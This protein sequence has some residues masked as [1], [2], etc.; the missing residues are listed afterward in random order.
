MWDYVDTQSDISDAA[1]YNA[2]MYLGEMFTKFTV[3]AMVSAVNEGRERHQYQL[4]YP[5]VR[6][7]GIGT[8]SQILDEVLTGVPAQ[9]LIENIKSEEKEV[10]QLTARTNAGAWQHSSV[11]LLFNCLRI[12]DPNSEPLPSKIQGKSWFSIF[13]ELRNKTRGHGAVPGGKISLM[14]PD[15]HKAI[16]T[17]AENFCLFRRP[18]AY[19][20]Q[21]RK[22]KYHVVRWSED[23]GA[24]DVL[25]RREGITY[26]FAEGLHILF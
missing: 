1:Y 14:C 24:L 3:A 15:L 18:W 10:Y 16:E 11:T 8:W 21:T 19:L 2:L 23:S 20:A 9:Y 22:R 7:D 6:A 12:A 4:R 25:K 13:A 26:S 5:L 17:F